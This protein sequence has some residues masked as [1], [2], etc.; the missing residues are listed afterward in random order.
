MFCNTTVLE[1]QQGI[2]DRNSGKNRS[3][4]LKHVIKKLFSI[5]HSRSSQI[6]HNSRFQVD[7]RRGLTRCHGQCTWQSVALLSDLRI[8]S[9]S[10]FFFPFPSFVVHDRLKSFHFHLTVV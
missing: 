9:L 6:Y 10:L 3:V 1:T 8:F 5:N 4:L 2:R 7:S